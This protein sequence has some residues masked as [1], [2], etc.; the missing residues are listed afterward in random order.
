MNKK[1]VNKE[2]GPRFRKIRKQLH[3]SLNELSAKIGATSSSALSRWERGEEGLP[4][5]VFEKIIF[6]LNISYS[7]LI[8]NEVEIKQVIGKVEL[9]YQNNDDRELNKFT[10]Q[11]LSAYYL[12]QDKY[13][14]TKL[15]IESAIAANFYLDLSGTDLTD[16]NYKKELA[17]QFGNIQYWFKKEV[18]LFG[19]I[20]LLL[21]ADTVYQLS[22]SLA[23]KFYEKDL[24]PLI[25]SITLLNAVFV[26]IKRKR[27][28]QARKVLTVTCK[29]NFS[30]NDLLSQTRIKFMEELVNYIDSR[31]ERAMRRFLNS[32]R[33][34]QLKESFEFAFLQVKKIYEI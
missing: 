7:D 30:I 19:D 6:E 27:L 4:V 16:K 17:K 29:L 14:K 12:E 33:E 25:V 13:I 8:A 10:S 15:L 24:V 23:S 21:D 11:L 1:I 20:Q 28:E 5:E 9:F 26:L 2:I 31:D 32:M 22:R 18:I 34:M 3:I